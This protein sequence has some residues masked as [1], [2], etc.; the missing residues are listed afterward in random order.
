MKARNVDYII[1]EVTVLF[2][3]AMYEQIELSRLDDNEV[4]FVVKTVARFRKKVQD[5]YKYLLRGPSV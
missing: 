4:T 5:E 3:E 1:D 2:T